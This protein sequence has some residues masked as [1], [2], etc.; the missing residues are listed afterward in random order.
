MSADAA[1][2]GAA[3][4]QAIL[5]SL[6]SGIERRAPDIGVRLAEVP[7]RDRG[8]ARPTAWAVAILTTDA[9]VALTLIRTALILPGAGRIQGPGCAG[10]VITS[11]RRFEAF[12]CRWAIDVL[13]ALARTTEAAATLALVIDAASV[14]KG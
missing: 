1:V 11:D 2:V 12:L 7:P 5:I 10:A 13:V 3:I 14:T 4:R 6:A 8:S 9:D